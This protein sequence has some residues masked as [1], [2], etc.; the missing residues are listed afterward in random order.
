MR[1]ILPRYP[2]Q[3][4]VLL[5]LASGNDKEIINVPNAISIAGYASTIAWL[6]G[7]SPLFAVAG[8]AADELDGPIARSRGETTDYGSLLDWGIDLTLTGAVALKVGLAPWLLLITPVQIWMRQN[9]MAPTF[10]SARAALTVYG[11]VKGLV[12]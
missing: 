11:L 12:K 7:A 5:G 10:G 3:S 9:E 2:S 6:M 4:K 1:S 8:I